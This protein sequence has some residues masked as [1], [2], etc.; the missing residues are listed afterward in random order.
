MFEILYLGNEPRKSYK[1]KLK[2]LREVVREFNVRN[3]VTKD[4]YIASTVFNES[5][6]VGMFAFDLKYYRLN[7]RYKKL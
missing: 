6:I 3:G 2:E 7:R 1:G 4:T 5:G